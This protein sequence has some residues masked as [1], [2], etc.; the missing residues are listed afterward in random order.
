MSPSGA[1]Q[2]C[3]AFGWNDSEVFGLPILL[4]ADD[5][6]RDPN[7]IF[8]VPFK[9]VRRMTQADLAEWAKETGTVM[10]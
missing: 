4:D 1:M 7:G 10:L 3:N 2:R 8:I 6:Q 5:K 9:N